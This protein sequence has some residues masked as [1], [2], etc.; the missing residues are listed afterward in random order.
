MNY[1]YKKTTEQL[2]KAL[3]FAKSNPEHP[4]SQ[5]LRRRMEAGQLNFELKA[6]GKEPVPLK[7][8]KLDLSG[9]KWQEAKPVQT[10]ASPVSDKVSTNGGNMSS[11]QRTQDS[12]LQDAEK[13]LADGF[14]QGG[15]QFMDAGQDIVDTALRDDRTVAEKTTMIGGRAFYGGGAG[16]GELILGAAK[17][18]LPQEAEDKLADIFVK[19]ADA[20][21][22]TE[23]VQ[24]LLAWHNSLDPRTRDQVDAALGFGAGLADLLGAKASKPVLEGAERV[25]KATLDAAGTAATQSAK[26]DFQ[27]TTNAAQFQLKQ[28][29]DALGQKIQAAFDKGVKPSLQGMKTPGEARKYQADVQ[30]AAK[31]ISQNK[32]NLTFR[33]AL[34]GEEI[35]GRSPQ[36]LTEFRDAI[37][38]TKSAVY[39]NY[40]NLA[41]Q[42][43]DNGLKVDM[44]PIA[45]RLDELIEND[46]IKISNP[47]AIR[48]AED[49]QSRLI[50]SGEL[51]ATVAQEVIQNYNNS[52]ASFYRNPTPDGLT[53]AATDAFMVNNM[54]Q[55]LDEGIEGISGAQYQ[56]LKNQYA[57]LKTIERD[58][59][60]ATLRD[61]RKNNASL[62]DFTD[63]FTIG[64]LAGAIANPADAVGAAASFGWKSWYKYLNNPNVQ[65][66]KMFKYADELPDDPTIVPISSRKQ[67]PAPKPDAPDTEN[68]VPIELPSR[69]Q[70]TVDAAEQA[71]IQE[72][73]KNNPEASAAAAAGGYF[74]FNDDDELLPLAAI[75]MMSPTMRQGARKQ[76]KEMIADAQNAAVNPRTSPAQAKVYEK[77]VN[78]LTKQLAEL[79]D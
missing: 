49:L 72:L 78:Q 55:A 41:E 68:Y 51:D 9:I 23:T 17:A 45:N 69:T 70:S 59:L 4:D 19:S 36:N 37:E 6:L 71:R 46:A 79:E 39:Q 50:K 63:I 5:E 20:V 33:D 22:E 24:D 31:V 47:D 30:T 15:Q 74:F 60:R 67:L 66:Q 77:R 34:T 1:D 12:F 58:V 44:T 57:A 2:K 29:N 43:G 75:G 73:I 26:T 52:L 3:E 76:L 10:A 8:K 48:Y 27:L 25:T 56:A 13:D 53:K 65:V 38:Q 54:R 28:A 14:V 18:V 16:I 40:N 32:D 61:A 11:V 7:K 35:V 62:I 64:Q 21:A 42:A